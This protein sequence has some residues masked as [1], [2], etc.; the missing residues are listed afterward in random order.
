MRCRICNAEE[1]DELFS[2]DCPGR[3][4]EAPIGDM[5]QDFANVTVLPGDGLAAYVCDGCLG[6]LERARVFKRACLQ[7]EDAYLSDTIHA[8]EKM[9]FQEGQPSHLVVELFATPIFETPKRVRCSVCGLKRSVRQI[10]KHCEGC[11]LDFDGLEP[12]NEYETDEKVELLVVVDSGNDEE[13]EVRPKRP[14]MA[15]RKRSPIKRVVSKS[16]AKTVQSDQEVT[17]F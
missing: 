15:D 10:V 5:L 4:G 17:H 2:L 6:L 9:E 13:S 12:S 16:S 8:W 11:K 7:A 14:R 1:C 3:D